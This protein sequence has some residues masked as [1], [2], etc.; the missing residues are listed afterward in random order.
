MEIEGP[1]SEEYLGNELSGPY[2]SKNFNS[3]GVA[4]INIERYQSHFE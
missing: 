1:E 2:R 4:A 3:D